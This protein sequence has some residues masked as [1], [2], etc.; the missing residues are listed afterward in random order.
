MRLWDIFN[1][2]H[3]CKHFLVFRYPAK[4]Q[5]LVP[6]S[7]PCSCYHLELQLFGSFPFSTKSY[8]KEKISGRSVPAI[9]F[10]YSV[11]KFCIQNSESQLKNLN[12]YYCCSALSVLQLSVSSCTRLHRPWCT[13]LAFSEKSWR[14]IQEKVPLLHIFIKHVRGISESK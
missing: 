4:G 1:L 12:W 10:I 8:L 7:W 6:V 11:A 2:T 9:E 3:I 5:H 13:A 14:R